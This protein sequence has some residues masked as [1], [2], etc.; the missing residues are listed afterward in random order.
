MV[1]EEIMKGMSGCWESGVW[2]ST[3]RIVHQVDT[4][5]SDWFHED[6]A[7]NNADCG[8]KSRICLQES[9]LSSHWK[10]NFSFSW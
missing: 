3:I 2:L 6:F 9:F 4:T 7:D 1:Q 5:Y 10:K 8:F